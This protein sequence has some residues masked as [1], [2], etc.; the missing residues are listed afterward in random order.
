MCHYDE[1]VGLA[2]D[3]KQRVHGER[4]REMDNEALVPHDVFET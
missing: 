2:A 3:C 4:K 1:G